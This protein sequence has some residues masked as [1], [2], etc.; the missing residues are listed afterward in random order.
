MNALT[1]F[2]LTQAA[3]TILCLAMDKHSTQAW[4]RKP[5]ATQR[6]SMRV[7]GWLLLA[8]GCA[9]C[10]KAFG[11]GIGLVMWFALLNAAGLL[12]ACLLP[13]RPRLLPWIAAAVATA[14]LL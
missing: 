10:V 9:F 8:A 11:V 2:S 12:L 14:A 7:L 6:V 3:M 5:S 13:Y 4:G 1:A